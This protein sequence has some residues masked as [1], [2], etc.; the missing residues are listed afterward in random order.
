MAKRRQT[1][2]V[3][4]EIALAMQADGL[5][6]EARA[7]LQRAFDIATVVGDP[8]AAA[9]LAVAIKALTSDD[10]AESPLRVLRKGR[11]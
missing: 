2:L 1:K 8:F 9:T 11:P 4:D 5:I 7:K 3:K 10:V 6:V